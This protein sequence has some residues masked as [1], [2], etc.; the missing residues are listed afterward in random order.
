M[1]NAKN[2]F[3]LP[4]IQVHLICTKKF[5]RPQDYLDICMFEYGLTQNL[6]WLDKV[7]TSWKIIA[8]KSCVSLHN[9]NIQRIYLL[10]FVYST[11]CVASCCDTFWWF[12][13]WMYIISYLIHLFRITWHH[14]INYIQMP[15]F[16]Y[17][18]IF[19]MRRDRADLACERVYLYCFDKY[20][21][22]NP[23]FQV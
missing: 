11:C 7:W 22:L 21:G 10:S 18:K 16:S 20:T 1:F 13:I 4:M 14:K 5:D 9:W 3:T 6:L 17:R 15:L 2:L 23:F 19:L 12:L 8:N